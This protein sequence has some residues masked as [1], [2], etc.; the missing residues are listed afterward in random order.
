[1]AA[2]TEFPA[3]RNENFTDTGQMTLG[4]IPTP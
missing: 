3:E 2:M 4:A 1:M